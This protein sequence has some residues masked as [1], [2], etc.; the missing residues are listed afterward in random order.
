MGAGWSRLRPCFLTLAVRTDQG[1]S[2]TS[3]K[4]GWRED[5]NLPTWE[6]AGELFDVVDRLRSR[7]A[8]QSVHRRLFFT[9]NIVPMKLTTVTLPCHSCPHPRILL[10]AK[11]R[12]SYC[13]TSHMYWRLIHAGG[14]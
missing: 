10:T 12:R 13:T 3:R 5:S 11:V 14:N 8:T 2:K 6:A 1:Q 4:G 7:R 9:M